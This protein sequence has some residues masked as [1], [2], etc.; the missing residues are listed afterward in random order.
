MVCSLAMCVIVL[1]GCRSN[2]PLHNETGSLV[3]NGWP[4][5][6]RL[7]ELRMWFLNENWIKK[8]YSNYIGSMM[9]LKWNFAHATAALLLWHVQNLI[10][11]GFLII[12]HYCISLMT[13]LEEFKPH[14]GIILCIC[15][16]NERWRCSVTSSFIGWAHIQNEYLVYLV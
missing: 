5:H 16:A 12:T 8:S 4:I 11:T 2:V 15:P 13:R 7:P 14:A 9:W 10:V 1:A 3:V 6:W